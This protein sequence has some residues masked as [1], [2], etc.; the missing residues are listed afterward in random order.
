MDDAIHIRLGM[1][2]ADEADQMQRKIMGK[3]PKGTIPTGQRYET[4]AEA[5]EYGGGVH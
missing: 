5:A 1:M 2:E 3:G 4:S